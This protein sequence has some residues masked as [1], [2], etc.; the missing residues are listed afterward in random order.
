MRSSGERLAYKFIADNKYSGSCTGIDRTHN[1][2]DGAMYCFAL[3]DER[4]REWLKLCATD[5][6]EERPIYFSEEAHRMFRCLSV[7]GHCP[8]MN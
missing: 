5:I 8:I 6:V 3:P 2:T 1:T 4:N 7:D